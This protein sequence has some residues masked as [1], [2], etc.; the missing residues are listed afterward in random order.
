M[1]GFLLKK[2]NMK[3]FQCIPSFTGKYIFVHFLHG[4]KVK[5]MLTKIVN[6]V[7]GIFW[8]T[9]F[10]FFSCFFMFYFLLGL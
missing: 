4:F 5:L 2:D 3:C 10:T 7:F 1:L 8:V 6:M 9:V